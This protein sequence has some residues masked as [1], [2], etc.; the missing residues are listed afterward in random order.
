MLLDL[1]GTGQMDVTAADALKELAGEL[2][3][4]DIELRLARVHKPVL[5]GFG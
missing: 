1:E 4:Q 3:R 2:E 5:A